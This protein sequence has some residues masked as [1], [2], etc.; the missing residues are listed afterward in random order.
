MKALMHPWGYSRGIATP[1]F[2]TA[3]ASTRR[4]EKDRLGARGGRRSRKIFDLVRFSTFV[5]L[6]DTEADAVASR[7]EA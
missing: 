6:L 3:P 4:V 1:S 5:D 7:A 2:M